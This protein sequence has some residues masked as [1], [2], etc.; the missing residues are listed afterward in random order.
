M[1]T[2]G[3]RRARGYSARLPWQ[4]GVYLCLCWAYGSDPLTTPD[5][6][7]LLAALANGE[8]R[9]VFA[10]ISVGETPGGSFT[11]G[12]LSPAKLARALGLLTD[13]GL[14]EAVETEGSA[15]YR[16]R[17]H[18]FRDALAS[19]SPAPR[20]PGVERFLTADGRID[21]YPARETELLKLLAW[22]A[23]RILSSSERVAERE[24]NERLAG[25]TDD[26]PMLRRRLVDYGVVVR[27]PDGSAYWLAREGNEDAH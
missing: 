26:V 19:L 1:R 22:V 21:R 12:K 9:R 8:A 15:R 23:A 7:R 20:R 16:I 25:L 27:T 11:P 10:E 18:V 24:L 14:V 5:A 2:A 6:R 4:F 3:E 13:A 17:E